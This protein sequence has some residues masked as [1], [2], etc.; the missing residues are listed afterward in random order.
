RK[1]NV[2]LNLTKQIIKKGVLMMMHGMY[3]FGPIWMY[4]LW[5]GLIILGVYLLIKFMNGD[6]KDV[7]KSENSSLE[8]LQQRLAKGE[9]DEAEYR[10][11][12]RRVG[13]ESRYRWT[14]CH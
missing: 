11:E 8:I 10:S 7:K 5:I 1:D 14:T 2:S 3:G 9:I 6:K 4:A 13:K 12:E